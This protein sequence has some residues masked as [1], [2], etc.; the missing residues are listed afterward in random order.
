[1]A[2]VETPVETTPEAEQ[3]GGETDVEKQAFLERLNKESG[4]RKEAEQRAKQAEQDMAGLRAQME[5][6]EQQG[7]PELDQLKKRLEQAEK[8]AEDAEKAKQDADIRL[9]R[10][11]KERWVTGAAQEQ[12]FADPT[13][14]SA[15]VNLDEI[16]DEKDAERAVKRLASQKK[17]LLKGEE[18]VLP[19]KVLADGRKAAPASAVNQPAE[20]EGLAAALKQFTNNWQ[21][22]E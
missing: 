1:M 20:A 6:R 22:F 13:D 5:E 21:T 7:L 17:H 18:K 12:N 19:G 4:K 10:G 3:N 14:A 15:F 9:V 11:Q 2:E 8:R 16:E